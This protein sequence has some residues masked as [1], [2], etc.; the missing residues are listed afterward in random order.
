MRTILLAITLL[1]NLP[2][3]LAQTGQYQGH[4]WKI[5]GNGLEKPSF[6]YGTMHVSNKVA[7]HLSDSFYKAIASVDVVALEINPETW[8]ETMTTNQY[9]ADRMGNA[10]SMR[11]DYSSNGFYKA[12]FLLEQPENKKIGEALGQELGILNSLLYRTSNYSADFQEDTYLDLFIFQAGKKQGKEITG[13]ESLG[14]TMRLNEQAAKPETD[15]D[16]RKQ[17]K[18]ERQRRSHIIQ[19]MLKDKSFQEVM[20]DAYRRGDLDLLDSL[21]R[22]SSNNDKYHE[23]IIVYRNIGMANAMD[24]IMKQKSLF[25]GIGAAHL[26]NSYGVIEL[27]REKGYT[28]VPVSTEKTEFGRNAKEELENTFITQS[29]TTKT[30]FDGSFSTAMPGPLYEFPESNN[31]MMAAYPDMANGATYVITRMMTF[32]PLH[33][34]TQ[35]QYMS[36]IDSLLYENIPGKIIDN[37]RITKGGYPG[38]DILNKTKKGDYQRYYIVVSPIEIII[39]KVGGKKEFVQRPEVD[40][41][42]SQLTFHNSS[43][44][45]WQKYS[46][47]NNAYKVDM[48]GNMTF[49]AENNAFARGYWKKNV[50]SFDPSDNSYYAVLN[51]SYSDYRFMEE[52][53]FELSQIS[54]QF[55]HQFEYKLTDWKIDSFQHYS[56]YRATAEKEG[57]DPLHL[58]LV[59][60]GEQYYL[61]LA[62][63]NN[64]TKVDRFISSFQFDT[65]H[66]SREFKLQK[67]T[68]LFFDVISPVEANPTVNYYG[69]YNEEDEDESYQ[70]ENKNATYYN[71]ETDET[72]Y[73]KYKKFHRYAS[74]LHIDSI[75]KTRKNYL[76]E[77]GDLYERNPKKW[78]ENGIYYYEAEASDTNT[79]RNI[80]GRYIL[81]DGIM[82]SLYTETEKFQE[83]SRFISTFFNSFQPW[84][85][86]IGDAVIAS[87]TERFLNDLRSEDSL[88]REGA[89]K[90]FGI[91]SFQ[92]DDAPKIIKALSKSYHEEHSLEIRASLLEQLAYLKHPSI[93]PFLEKKY[94]EVEDTI[95]LQLPIL[96]AVAYQRTKKSTKLFYKLLESETPL[97]N[98]KYVINQLFNGFG[99]SLSLTKEFYPDMLL[100][101]SLPEY[102]YKSYYYLATLMDS[103]LISKRLYKR[104]LKQI[105]WEA[106]NEV[107]R[108]KSEEAGFEKDY[109]ETASRY[110]R[111]D[112]DYSLYS[113]SVLLM[114]FQKKNGKVKKYFTRL[115]QLKSPA[116]RIDLAVLRAKNGIAVPDSVWV[117][118]AKDDNDRI[119]LYN[120]LEKA[121][122][123]NLFPEQYS[124]QHDLALSMY[125]DMNNLS[126]SRDSVTFVKR[127]HTIIEKDTGFIY[128]FKTK[129]TYNENWNMGYIGILAEDSSSLKLNGYHYDDNMS[130]SKFD[131]LDLQIE[132]QIRRMQMS[133]RQRYRVEDEPKFKELNYR[134]RY[135]Y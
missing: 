59:L 17:Q 26:P 1:L 14:L 95:R 3:I 32:G 91:I 115:D 25:A 79:N 97:S 62:K 129:S 105:V 10:F 83:R 102:K 70:E 77:Y 36:K 58:R 123:L 39:F 109:F 34:M 81:K 47:T 46:P 19:K 76:T 45:Q 67:D 15:K 121:D 135:Y 90:S 89:F 42:F 73:V 124:S 29:F 30:S 116:L 55:S 75:W 52:D 110:K 63:S 20:E 8:M 65:F 31:V 51:R 122:L 80:I 74:E 78:T 125:A 48:P 28:V 100:L 44:N 112:Y 134:R 11:G 33:G 6:L 86:T 23:L 131:D 60:K 106:N 103:G 68:L 92:N 7:F 2:L 54:R 128:F 88:T 111:Y 37:K 57:Q 127:V 40:A 64:E 61:L 120:A 132:M 119:V 16:K 126:A 133:K 117:N 38:F 114:P 56:G 72:I 22:M 5:S 130:Y 49:E 12:I 4:L 87:K 94:A 27:L 24:S 53:S 113:Y 84:D 41:F 82:Y 101:S 50:Q 96:Q 18:L 43:K 13:L 108:Q 104:K 9:V 93:L 99:D 69:Y 66:Y 118:F 98:D 85:T 107:K 71:K 21:S 35:D